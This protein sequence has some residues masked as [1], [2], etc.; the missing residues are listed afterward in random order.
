VRVARRDLGG[1]DVERFFDVSSP[2]G[3]VVPFGG[4]WAGDM[5]LSG[6]GEGGVVEPPAPGDAFQP[7]EYLS[8]IGGPAERAL[9]DAPEAVDEPRPDLPPREEPPGLANPEEPQGDEPRAPGQAPCT[10][11]ADFAKS[12]FTPQQVEAKGKGGEEEPEPEYGI[13]F[14]QDPCPCFCFC[15]HFGSIAS[16]FVKAGKLLG[17]IFDLFRKDEKSILG[18]SSEPTVVLATPDG[19]VEHIR[20]VVGPGIPGIGAEPLVPADGTTL[21]AAPGSLFAGA[22]PAGDVF[23][24][25]MRGRAARP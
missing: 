8:R 19:F 3:V 22:A 15:L 2:E 1:L 24:P 16:V 5:P 25:D 23:G 20:D 12:P 9:L 14:Y 6:A 11:D 10:Q 13:A 18:I 17:S 21:R 4:A 7:P